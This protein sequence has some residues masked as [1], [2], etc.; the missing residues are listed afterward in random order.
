MNNN[1]N[2]NFMNNN[3][4]ANKLANTIRNVQSS[5][6]GKLVFIFILFAILLIVLIL[7]IKNTLHSQRMR[8]RLVKNT[9]FIEMERG[10]NPYD[11]WCGKQDPNALPSYV[12]YDEKIYTYNCSQ[13][14]PD[15]NTRTYKNNEDSIS[16]HTNNKKWF[17]GTTEIDKDHIKIPEDLK[18]SKCQDLCI[19]DKSG[20][21]EIPSDI[22][23]I[24][25]ANHSLMF[26]FK[27]NKNN[28]NSSKS[29]N[30]PFS[31]NNE[32]GLDYPLIY[33]SDSDITPNFNKCN[34]FGFYIKPINNT[35]SVVKDG[36]QLTSIY[37]L[38]Y[39]TW[40]CVSYIKNS[41][42]IEVYINGKL[43]KTISIDGTDYI[44]VFQSRLKWGPYPGKL[45]FVE[46]NKDLD[47]LNSQSVF[48]SYKYY[49]SLINKYETSRDNELLGK[50]QLQS[51]PF[52]KTS[53]WKKMF[54]SG[55]NSNLVCY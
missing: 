26:W 44:K 16:Y 18:L 41:N 3:N 54:A 11:A 21:T 20:Y 9:F 38:P 32:L 34:A 23:N 1:N 52:R 5:K 45:A 10:L 13:I 48:E 19:Y 42:S 33:F 37:N 50:I 36:K 7:V 15:V 55:G 17:D 2:N 31:N 24:G 6:K 53:E 25:D 49:R 40:T 30:Y 35:M 27:I 29:S 8:N 12:E 22:T 51:F 4:S 43:L 28:S 39:D 46:T 47:D 14:E